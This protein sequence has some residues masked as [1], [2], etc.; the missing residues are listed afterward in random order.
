LGAIRPIAVL[1]QRQ[2][3]M[4][5]FKIFDRTMLMAAIVMAALLIYLAIFM[6][7]WIIGIE[8]MESLEKFISASSG[9]M[10]SLLI[11]AG[12]AFTIAFLVMFVCWLCKDEGGIM[13]LPFEVAEGEEKYSG[14]AVS[15]LLTA[16]LQ[17]I[18]QINKIEI[19]PIQ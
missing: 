19:L 8:K 9:V 2:A 10:I 1:A 6:M 15:H 12:A 16:E 18:E 4:R 17:R 13:I 5:E 7:A 3:E 14:K 11:I